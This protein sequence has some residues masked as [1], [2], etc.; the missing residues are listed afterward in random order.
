MRQHNF[1]EI[2]ISVPVLDGPNEINL[3]SNLLTRFPTE[4]TQMT[5]VDSISLYERNK[6]KTKSSQI[7]SKQNKQTK[8]NKPIQ[9]NNTK[10]IKTKQYKTYTE[11]IICFLVLFP[12]N[13]S[14]C[15]QFES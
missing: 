14:Q 1:T 6:S 13:F 4:L 8:Q 9:N 15:N 7:K 11:P 2:N 3:S 5:M 10:Q 12:L